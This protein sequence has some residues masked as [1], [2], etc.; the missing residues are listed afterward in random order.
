MSTRSSPR[1]DDKKLLQCHAHA[2]LSVLDQLQAAAAASLTC[3]PYTICMPLITARGALIWCQACNQTLHDAESGNRQ[4]AEP[5]TSGGLVLLRSRSGS[6]RAMQTTTWTCL[7][8]GAR[9]Q[10]TARAAG[11]CA[12][13]PRY[14]QTSNENAERKRARG[15][16]SS[17]AVVTRCNTTCIASGAASARLRRHRL[18]Q[19][20]AAHMRWDHAKHR[21]E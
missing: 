3:T 5:L 19:Q 15:A 17:A 21:L 6:R 1:L 18:L 2:M 13:R 16:Y 14:M 20:H 9:R 10:H 11:P 8:T 12:A 7:E 4:V